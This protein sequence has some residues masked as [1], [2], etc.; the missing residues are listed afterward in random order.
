VLL[1]SHQTRSTREK[2]SVL[3]ASLYSGNLSGARLYKVMS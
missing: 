3:K 1:A 2:V